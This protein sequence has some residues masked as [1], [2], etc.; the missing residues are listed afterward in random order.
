MKYLNDSYIEKT[1]KLLNE[2]NDIIDFKIEQ[3]TIENFEI[4]KQ[5]MRKK[6]TLEKV[7]KINFNDRYCIVNLIDLLENYQTHDKNIVINTFIEM[8]TIKENV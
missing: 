8:F 7:L 6:N 2:V 4:L 5:L 1:Q 3:G